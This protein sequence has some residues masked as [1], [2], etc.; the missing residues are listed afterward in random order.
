[1]NE[2]REKTPEALGGEAGH[3]E[4][5]RSP[6]SS[7]GARVHVRRPDTLSVSEVASLFG[8]SEDAVLELVSRRRAPLRQD[9]FSFGELAERWRCSCGT[10]YNRLRA[11]GAKVLDFAPPGKRGKKAVPASIVLQMEARYMRRLR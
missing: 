3:A 11:A 6:D 10:V 1:M 8:L 5:H 4:R 9:F 7:P 2:V